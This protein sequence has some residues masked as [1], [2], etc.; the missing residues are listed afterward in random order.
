MP[1][2]E[3]YHLIVVTDLPRERFAR[4]RIQVARTLDEALALAAEANGGSL[5]GVETTL[6]PHGGQHL[7]PAP[8]VTLSLYRI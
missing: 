2:S 3:N 7:S 5:K 6:M 1:S 8:G 4:T